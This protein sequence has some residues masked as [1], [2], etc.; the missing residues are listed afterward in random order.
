MKKRHF[1]PLNG[2]AEK[3]KVASPCETAKNPW[4]RKGLT[5]NHTQ[6]DVCH[7]CKAINY[8]RETADEGWT[9]VSHHVCSMLQ[10]L[11]SKSISISFPRLQFDGNLQDLRWLEISIW[12]QAT[13][14]LQCLQSFCRKCCPARDQGGTSTTCKH[15]KTLV[16]S[17]V[18]RTCGQKWTECKCWQ[19][20]QGSILGVALNLKGKFRGRCAS[21]IDSYRTKNDNAWNRNLTIILHVENSITSNYFPEKVEWLGCKSRN[22]DGCQKPK[23]SPWARESADSVTSGQGDGTKTYKN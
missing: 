11:Y 3:E 6:F 14:E 22:A 1:V 10:C 13:R 2:K 17:D 16:F 9:S 19:G 8:T 7:I 12:A 18:L 5:K 20:W 23:A 4:Q 21:N 15:M